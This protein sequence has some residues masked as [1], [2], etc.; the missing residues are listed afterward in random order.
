MELRRLCD[1]HGPYL[2]HLLAA[3]SPSQQ[4][5]RAMA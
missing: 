5:A 4:I 3:G 2:L 1:A